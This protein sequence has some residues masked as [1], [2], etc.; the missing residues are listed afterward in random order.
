MSTETERSGLPAYEYATVRIEDHAE[1]W[2]NSFWNT[3]GSLN[4]NSFVVPNEG[5]PSLDGPLPSFAF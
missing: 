4:D 5:C 1:D 2:P 3:Y